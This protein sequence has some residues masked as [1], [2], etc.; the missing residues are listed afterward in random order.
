[1]EGLTK[2]GTFHGRAMVS[3]IAGL[4][5]AQPDAI[6]GNHVIGIKSPAVSGYVSPIRSSSRIPGRARPAGSKLARKAKGHKLGG[7]R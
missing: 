7:R 3:A 6:I 1:M 5:A 4:I 2:V